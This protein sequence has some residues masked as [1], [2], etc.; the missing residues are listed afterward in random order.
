MS[1]VEHWFGRFGF[2]SILGLFVSF[3]PGIRIF[4]ANAPETKWQNGDRFCEEKDG[5][6]EGTRNQALGL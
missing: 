1:S 2:P 5:R 3:F 4:P 6:T